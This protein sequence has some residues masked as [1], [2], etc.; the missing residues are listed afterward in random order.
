MKTQ[1]SGA[2]RT[3]EAP[4]FAPAKIPAGPQ[5]VF[6]SGVSLKSLGNAGGLVSRAWRWIREQLEARSGNKRLQLA[7]T[8]SLGDKR[9][10]AVLK[11][12]GQEFLV[13]GGA[14][15]VQLLAWL[16]SKEPFG[17]L[18][19]ETMGATSAPTAPIEVPAKRTRKRT[20]KS[21]A[22]Q[23]REQD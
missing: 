23:M 20:G 12:D 1:R 17:D 18:L 4:V 19:Q 8:V 5:L 10:V 21:A 3:M 22:E 7:A 14:G 16:D 6:P 9:F 2:L 15:N 13:G 11:V